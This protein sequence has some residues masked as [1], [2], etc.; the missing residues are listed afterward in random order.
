MIDGVEV[1]QPKKLGEVFN[2]LYNAKNP[3]ELKNSKYFGLGEK[4]EKELN[5][6]FKAVK[7]KAEFFEDIELV[8]YFIKPKYPLK[9]PLINKISNELFP[10]KTVVVVQDLGED[11]LE[12]SARRQ[13]FKLAVNELLEKACKGFLESRS[14]GHKPAAGARIKR[15]DLKK[16][17]ENLLSILKEK[18]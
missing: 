1:M 7:E 9:A 3:L 6:W 5:Y 11:F 15:K 17:K 4:L 8:Y 12:I 16:F 14:G 2:A 13:D 18:N 10:N